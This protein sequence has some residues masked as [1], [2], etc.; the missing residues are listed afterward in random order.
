MVEMDNVKGSNTTEC[1]Y[2]HLCISK[3]SG[4]D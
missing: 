1:Y 4:Q 2:G 3:A